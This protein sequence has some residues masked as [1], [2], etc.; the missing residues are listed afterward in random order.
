MGASL[1]AIRILLL[2]LLVVLLAPEASAQQSGGASLRLRVVE[3]S[4]RG[5]I[6]GAHVTFPELYRFWISD[7]Q[8][9]A[10]IA[11][12][13]PGEHRVEVSAYGFLPFQA[14]LFFAADGSAE[15]EARLERDPLE[16]LENALVVVS[17]SS[18]GLGD[19]S[20][21]V[22]VTDADTR[23]PVVGARV[24]FEDAFRYWITDPIGRASVSGIAP[25]VHQVEVTRLGYAPLRGEL[26]IEPGA[27]AQVDVTL[28]SR[29]VGIEGVTVAVRSAPGL[30]VATTPMGRSGFFDRYRIAVGHQLDRRDIE[31]TNLSTPS[32]VFSQIP[33]VRLARNDRDDWVVVNPRTTDARPATVA[34]GAMRRGE[35]LPGRGC[36]MTYYLD[37]VPWDGEVDDLS[38]D[39]IE[40]L[41][42]Y[43]GPSQIPPAYSRTDN[44]CGV[45][46]IW[47]RTGM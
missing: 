41:E 5:P 26:K 17:S 31:A 27:V 29:P 35:M 14:V 19:A 39:W 33:G 20:L 32:D 46:L 34:P 21:S 6:V 9:Y 40:A 7:S 30:A 18:T 37:G 10:T 2:P 24:T 43:T 23:Q 22:R 13:P 42:V 11:S 16:R 44:N 15:A 36:R 45:V 12:V 38:L 25:G 3:A 47:T 1:G 28:T 4:S 8:G